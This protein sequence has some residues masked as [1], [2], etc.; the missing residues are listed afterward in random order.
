MG[1]TS[2]T[3]TT[4]KYVT[5]PP[6]KPTNPKMGLAVETYKGSG[7]YY[8]SFGGIPKADWSGIAVGNDSIVSDLC[9][10]SLDPGQSQKSVQYRTRPLRLKLAG[11]KNLKEFQEEVW[12]HLTKYGLDTLAYLPDP[13]DK[14]EVL[15]VVE[16]HAKFTGDIEEAFKLAQEFKD[17]FD[18]WDKSMTMNA[19][20]S[21][22]IH[23]IMNY[24][25][26]SNLFVNSRCHLQEHGYV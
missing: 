21:Y 25:R 18:D 22:W 13:M 24:I 1:D 6:T 2:P 17:K 14:T 7:S 19:R 20:P 10:R 3:K 15:N 11:K 26:G 23:L 12:K 16:H 4:I 8:L 5:A 9:Y